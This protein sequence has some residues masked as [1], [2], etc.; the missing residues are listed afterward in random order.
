[1][2]RHRR[3]QTVAAD[4]GATGKQRIEIDDTLFLGEPAALDPSKQSTLGKRKREGE[5]LVP[6]IMHFSFGL[7]ELFSK[8]LGVQV[9]VVR[10]VICDHSICLGFLDPPRPLANQCKWC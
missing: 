1:M 9:P 5:D 7:A 3:G 4:A 10:V 2:G 8:K 6:S